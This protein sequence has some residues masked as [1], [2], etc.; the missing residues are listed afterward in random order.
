MLNFTVLNELLASKSSKN[1]KRFTNEKKIR[2]TIYTW[3]ITNRRNTHFV[4]S[5]APFKTLVTALKKRHLAQELIEK[6]FTIIE[7]KILSCKKKTG[8]YG[9]N[10]CQ[11][12]VL[13]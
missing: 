12:F 4:K 6:I 1:K 3:T 9:M 11:V 2:A 5:R 10:L 13:A 8:R 7:Q